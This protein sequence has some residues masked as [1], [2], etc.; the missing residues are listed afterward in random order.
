MPMIQVADCQIPVAP[1]QVIL[2]AVAREFRVSVHAIR[3]PQRHDR[4]V[5]PRQ[6][7]MY[8]LREIL[9]LS[10]TRIG[11]VTRHDHTTAIYAHA[12]CVKEFETK[13]E[14]AQK[15][16]RLEDYLRARLQKPKGQMFRY[17]THARAD[18]YLRL[19]WMPTTSLEGTYHGQWSVLMK[20]ICPSCPIVEPRS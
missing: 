12:R 18:A 17:V 20:W 1:H 4:L 19:G 6:A 9:G 16:N 8:L 15:I 2:R 11:Q 10:W 7:A 3:C 5:K 14:L 13:T